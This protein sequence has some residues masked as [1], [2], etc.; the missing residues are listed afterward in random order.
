MD[1]FMKTIFPELAAPGLEPTNNEGNFLI[2]S[3][4]IANL[5]FNGFPYSRHFTLD[6]GMTWLGRTTA[7]M[8]GATS[9]LDGISKDYL[10]PEGTINMQTLAA[11]IKTQCGLQTAIYSSHMANAERWSYADNH[12]A[13]LVN[14]LRWI[15]LKQLSDVNEGRGLSGN[16]TDYD[17]GHIKIERKKI[18]A[19][20]HIDDE[21]IKLGWPG[22]IDPESYPVIAHQVLF[23]PDTDSDMIDL[24]GTTD[25]EATFILSM[26]G[27]WKRSSRYMLD[28]STPALTSSVSYRRGNRAQSAEA[29]LACEDG[30]AGITPELPTLKQAWGALTRYITVNRLYD[31]WAVAVQLVS[32]I[33]C[34]MM[35]DTAEGQAWLAIERSVAIPRFSS[36][37]GRYPI[38]NE[39]EAALLN[40]RALREWSYLGSRLERLYLYAACLAQAYQTGAAVRGVRRQNE[41][42]PVDIESTAGWTVS[43]DTHYASY[44]SEATRSPAPLNIMSDAYVNIDVLNN[45]RFTDIVSVEVQT[46][47]AD[48]YD[49]K[50]RCGKHYLDVNIAPQPGVPNLLLPLQPYHVPTP[51]GLSIVIDIP[52]SKKGR[53]GCALDPYEAWNLAWVARICGY[54]VRV[55]K[56]TQTRGPK[57]FFASNETSWTHSMQLEE[58]EEGEKIRIVGI[59]PRD[60]VFIPFPPVHTKRFDGVVKFQMQPIDVVVRGRVG[61]R[62]ARIADYGTISGMMTSSDIRL[63]VPEGIMKLRASVLRTQQDFQIVGSVQAG[64]I[65]TGD[66][67]VSVE[68]VDDQEAAGGPD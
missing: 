22:G 31:H 32:Q 10:T 51:Y 49:I 3:R 18:L 17:D 38:L 58:Y 64:V 13:L 45:G 11:A 16:W 29:W 57:R 4:M 39:G 36:F 34:Q 67:S 33:A 52:M 62:G 68:V 14:M 56:D 2:S 30:S 46:A 37:R 53:T 59:E 54:D 27:P 55:R 15:W 43:V 41:E 5:T 61:E 47:A 9:N 20:V 6:Q 50:T 24:R 28:F 7:Y 26:L 19:A 42:H 66:S 35:P 40:H 48:G 23:V 12:V 63:N 21:H 25:I 65:P 8:S 44:V 60:N 1:N